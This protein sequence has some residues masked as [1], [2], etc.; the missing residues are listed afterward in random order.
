MWRDDSPDVP[1]SD[2][3]NWQTSPPALLY[4]PPVDRHERK[5]ISGPSLFCPFRA[6]VPEP[7]YRRRGSSSLSARISGSHRPTVPTYGLH[8]QPNRRVSSDLARFLRVHRSPIGG[9]AAGDRNT[10]LSAHGPEDQVQRVPDR[11]VDAAPVPAR[12]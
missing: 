1:T 4:C 3:A 5:S 7:V 9:R 8:R 10:F 12:L 6:P 11:S 2:P